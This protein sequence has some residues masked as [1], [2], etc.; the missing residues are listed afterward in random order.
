[1]YGKCFIHLVDL[2]RMLG[3]SDDKTFRARF[4]KAIKYGGRLFI[5]TSDIRRYLHRS[6]MDDEK[7]EAVRLLLTDLERA[8]ADWQQA[9]D[10]GQSPS[11]IGQPPYTG[12]Q[13]SSLKLNPLEQPSEIGQQATGG[14][15]QSGLK[16]NPVEQPSNFGQQSGLKL[17]PIEKS[18]EIELLRQEVNL[19]WKAV[20]RLTALSGQA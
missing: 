18:S 20:G 12:G 2:S 4:E 6:R 7:I 16:P 10:G 19:L 9:T 15:Q 1:M 3:I 11:E 13:Q 5:E 8:T 17:N 14:G